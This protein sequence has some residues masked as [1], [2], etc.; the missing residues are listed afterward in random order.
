[1]LDLIAYRLELAG[2]RVVKLDGRMTFDARD[3]HIASFCED[4][5]TRVFLISL[6]VRSLLPPSCTPAQKPPQQETLRSNSF[7]A[8]KPLPPSPLPALPPPPHPLSPL[9]SSC[10][11]AA[12]SQVAE[13]GTGWRGRPEPDGGECGVHNGPLVEPG[14]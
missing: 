5:D 6:K 11:G 10:R 2:I 7:P 8:G 3:R 1:M 13:L 9:P 14:G 12:S 4:P